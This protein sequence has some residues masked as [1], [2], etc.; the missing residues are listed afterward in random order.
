MGKEADKEPSRRQ[1]AR[2]R[3]SEADALPAGSTISSLSSESPA[4]QQAE[5]F[6]ANGVP[7]SQSLGADRES[8]RRSS[9]RQQGKEAASEDPQGS[10]AHNDVP[11]VSPGL[12]DRARPEDPSS[13]RP[14]G[15]GRKRRRA[16][17]EPQ[18]VA[19]PAP[20]VAPAADDY[21]QDLQGSEEEEAGVA[22]D[23]EEA[24]EAGEVGGAAP[25]A[26]QQQPNAGERARQRFLEIARRRAAHF[27]HFQGDEDAG[28][29]AGGGEAAEA[30]RAPGG[31]QRAEQPPRAEQEDWPGPFSTARRL[32]EGRAAAVA[33][34]EGQLAGAGEE[35]GAKKPRHVANMCAL[36]VSAHIEHVESLVGVPDAV[37]RSLSAILSRRRKMVPRT[38]ALLLEGAVSEICAAD[39]SLIS[40]PDLTQALAQ[41]VPTRLEALELGMC[42][43]GLSDQGLTATIAASPNCLPQLTTV[44]LRGAYRV[45]DRSLLALAAAAPN[46]TS[47]ELQHCPLITHEGVAAIAGVKLLAPAA[48]GTL[49]GKAGG[50]LAGGA[51]A[52]GG[53]MSAMRVLPALC[54]LSVLERLNLGGV[55]SVTDGVAS[56]VDEALAALVTASGGSLRKLSVNSVKNAGD[57]LLEA[58][59]AHASATLQEIDVSFCRAVSDQGLGLLA[60]SCASLRRVI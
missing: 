5:Q 8:S 28:A 56:E 10:A 53:S 23:V 3:R 32:V 11:L 57:L 51:F 55:G 9:G 49:G 47:L 6:D 24:G 4:Q 50:D 48:R 22:E 60:D 36:L 54:Q 35:A 30:Q 27:A 14:Q 25:V 41:C 42:G 33:A 43:R 12:E 26:R 38:L 29:G 15:T 44:A 58:L 52:G 40:E 20:L 18:P 16:E 46:L 21:A 1:S 31:G 2:L 45:T 34:R 7:G 19:P 17:T 13:S 37:R 39:C 59:A